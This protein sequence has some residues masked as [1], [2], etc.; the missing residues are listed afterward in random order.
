VDTG[1]ERIRAAWWR[2]FLT[3]WGLV[4]AFVVAAF[5]LTALVGAWSFVND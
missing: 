2:A 3:G 4:L 5:V 1:E